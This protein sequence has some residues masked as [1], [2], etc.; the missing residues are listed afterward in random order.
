MLLFCGILN[1]KKYSPGFWKFMFV[2]SPFTY[3]VQ[4]FAAP[5]VHDRELR[6]EPDEFFIMDPPSG[7]NCGS[8]LKPFVGTSGGYIDNPEA[9]SQCLYCPYT[10]QGQVVEQF[11]IK[12][13]YHWRDFGIAW[14]YII[15]NV[16]AMMF[17][18]WFF[19]VQKCSIGSLFNVKKW[20]AKKHVDRHEKDNTIF[21]PKAGDDQ[22][23]VPRKE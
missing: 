17:G 10:K 15:F 1:P 19:R 18:Y 5:I 12:W 7:E 23:L 3:F 20:F 16:F 4:A 13:G 14:I 8:Y 21:A 9:E 2:V 11:K 6:C 22:I